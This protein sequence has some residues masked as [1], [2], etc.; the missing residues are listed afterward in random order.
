MP[1]VKN[2]IIKEA[3]NRISSMLCYCCLCADLQKSILNENGVKGLKMA[4]DYEG[5]ICGSVETIKGIAN[6]ALRRYNLY[7]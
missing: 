3:I 7:K 4:S 5:M 6:E 2:E 1:K